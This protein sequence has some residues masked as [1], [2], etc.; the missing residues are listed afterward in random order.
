MEIK[1]KRTKS[2]NKVKLIDQVSV[3]QKIEFKLKL[4]LLSKRN[5][6]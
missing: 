5:K 1:I 2:S 4:I 3:L 6:P